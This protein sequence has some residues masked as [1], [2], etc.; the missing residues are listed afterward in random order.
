MM[1][2]GNIVSSLI[3]IC[4]YKKYTERAKSIFT[5]KNVKFIPKC[6][7]TYGP[8]YT[9]HIVYVKSV[10]YVPYIANLCEYTIKYKKFC[11]YT[12]VH[13]RLNVRICITAN[14]CGSNFLSCLN[15]KLA[16]VGLRDFYV[17]IYYKISQNYSDKLS[18]LH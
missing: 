18:I 13:L 12:C 4:M 6:K 3:L 14:K 2:C 15:S 7:L 16:S 1:L 17:V 5:I 8:P 9:Y 11:L 10:N